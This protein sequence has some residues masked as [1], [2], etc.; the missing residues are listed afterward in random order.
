MYFRATRKPQT[1]VLDS[2]PELRNLR[3]WVANPSMPTV[4]IDWMYS[5]IFDAISNSR[6]NTWKQE[7][8][9]VADRMAFGDMLYGHSDMTQMER[10]DLALRI[11]SAG[12]S[13]VHY[14]LR[15]RAYENDGYFPYA[16]SQFRSDGLLVFLARQRMAG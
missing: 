11:I 6:E 15:M 1:L 5:Q 14:L 12:Q 10:D 8:Y 9:G 4:D 3:A 13:F 2:P 16:F 7:L